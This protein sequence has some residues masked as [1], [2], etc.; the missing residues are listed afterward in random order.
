MAI[1]KMLPPPSPG[2]KRPAITA[3]SLGSAVHF[4]ATPAEGMEK[5]YQEILHLFELPR[6]N[7]PP[8]RRGLGGRAP[9]KFNYIIYGH[10]IGPPR[11]V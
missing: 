4:A 2:Q 3:E 11:P 10:K 1:A 5:R 9:Q 8:P 7:R 6:G